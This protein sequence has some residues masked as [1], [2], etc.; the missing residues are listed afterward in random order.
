MTR[1]SAPLVSLRKRLGETLWRE[2]SELSQAYLARELSNG[3]LSLSTT[4]WLGYCVRPWAAKTL[5]CASACGCAL[6]AQPC[7]CPQRDLSGRTVRGRC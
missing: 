7:I 2:R 3:A 1:S 4:A 6:R 5:V